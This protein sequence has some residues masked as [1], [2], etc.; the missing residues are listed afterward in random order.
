MKHTYK[1]I[2]DSGRVVYINADSRTAAIEKYHSESGIPKD[3]IKKHC[4]IVNEGEA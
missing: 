2:F 4:L 1:F 3:F